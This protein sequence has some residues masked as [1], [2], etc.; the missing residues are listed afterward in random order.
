MKLVS[1]TKTF[2]MDLEDSLGFDTI[3]NMLDDHTRVMIQIGWFLFHLET[4]KNGMAYYVTY[5]KSEDW[6]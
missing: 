1:Q 6:W 2:E 4:V 3:Q 5:K